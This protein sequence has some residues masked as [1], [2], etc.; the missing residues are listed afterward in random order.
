M[1]HNNTAHI[2]VIIDPRKIHI[3]TSPIISADVVPIVTKSRN[4]TMMTSTLLQMD[5][6]D[7]III[8]TDHMIQFTY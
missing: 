7:H 2:D 4:I 6:K 1:P 3:P 5:Y 8:T